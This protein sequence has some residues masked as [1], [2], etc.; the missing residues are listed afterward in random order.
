MKTGLDGVVAAETV[1][2]HSDPQASRLWVRGVPLDKA[3]RDLGYEG[4]VSLLWDGFAGA[5]TREQIIAAFGAGRQRAFDRLGSW[6][7]EVA[8]TAG[9]ATRQCLA[10]LTSESTPADIVG[11][12]TV[13]VPAIMRRQRGLAPV[14]P[15][16]TLTTAAD[17]LK[18]L[19]GTL[20]APGMVDALDSYF[21]VAAENGLGPSTLA[22]RVVA[23]TGASHPAAVLAAYCAFEG[24]LH[25]GAP[26]PALTMLDEARAS[27]N[28][29]AWLDRKLAA[30]ARLVGFGNRA[31]PNGDPRAALLADAV[32][33]LGGDNARLQFA[34]EFER[35]ALAALARHRPD[36][37]LRP[38]LEIYAAL[39]LEACGIPRDAFTPTFATSRAVGWL[40]HAMEQ[41]AT[42]RMLRPTSRYVGPA[43]SA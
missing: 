13:G 35:L 30:G 24:P 7:Q 26:G 34:A 39:L 10:A 8:G 28:V 15:D 31:F 3:A 20:A 23:S 22:A 17:F 21:A 41:K 11:A 1:L 40:A 12:L 19:S 38:N 27:G 9:E 32:R 37:P 4:L 42:G 18:M 33:K 6:L 43:L 25:G 5:L 29:A 36:K 2:S 14:A 16:P